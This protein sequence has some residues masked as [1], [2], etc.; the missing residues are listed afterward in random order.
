MKPRKRVLVVP[1]EK[2]YVRGR[3]VFQLVMPVLVM[4][5]AGILVVLTASASLLVLPGV[6][7]ARRSANW[8][9]PLLLRSAAE[10]ADRTQRSA[11]D[12]ARASVALARRIRDTAIE[13]PGRF[14]RSR[15]P[16]ALTV[17]AV[18]CLMVVPSWAHPV[19][20][21]AVA[22]QSAPVSSDGGVRLAPADAFTGTALDWNQVRAAP[23]RTD[24]AGAG[25]AVACANGCDRQQWDNQ[26]SQ[27]GDHAKKKKKKSKDES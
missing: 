24:T 19:Y 8:L 17:A 11:A 23:P 2:L 16:Q 3:L 7:F 18:A 21:T 20:E 10:V 12:L 5:G 14:V 26:K 25:P 27:S 22:V 9:I 1:G 4:I 15:L 13:L 6:Y